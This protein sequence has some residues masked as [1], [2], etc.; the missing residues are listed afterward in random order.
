MV[1][2]KEKKRV[3]IAKAPFR[4]V[5]MVVGGTGLIIKGAGHGLCWLGRK[6][7]MGPSGGQWVAEADVGK[8]GKV[9]TVAKVASPASTRK[10]IKIFNDNGEKVWKDEDDTASTT[11]G[12]L[13]DEKTQK[14]FC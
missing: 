11:A 3:I 1:L 12:S 4:G 10:E 6:V 14:E 8:D 9:K 7:S 5:A 2:I 13:Y